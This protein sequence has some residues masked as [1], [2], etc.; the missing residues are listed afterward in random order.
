[1]SEDQIYLYDWLFHYNPYTKK[2]AAFPKD[3]KNEYFIN[4][5]HPSVI[6]S[7]SINTL[8]EL[9]QRTEGDTDKLE[10]LANKK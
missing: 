8:I 1:M 6:R 10:K 9:L 7:S 3:L 5:N 2:W 4:Y